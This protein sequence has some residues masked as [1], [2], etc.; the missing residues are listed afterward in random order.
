M[1]AN[2]AK[3][4]GLPRYIPHWLR[5]PWG[6][7]AGVATLYILLYY[8]W[9]YFHWG[10]DDAIIFIGDLSPL[11]VSLFASLAAWRVAADPRLDR[12]LRQAWLFLGLCVFSQFIADAIWSYIEIVL[13]VDAF[14]SAADI[15]YLLFYPMA[16]I[17]LV[18]FREAPLSQGDRLKFA[19]D[20][21]IVMIAAWM[22]IWYFIIVPTAAAN[23]GDLLSQVLAAAYPIGDLVVL[24]G[25]VALLFR[26]PEGATRAAL[27]IFLAGLLVFIAGDL[28]YGYTSLLETYETGGWIDLTW[29]TA[30]LLFAFAALR[31]PY[32]SEATAAEE[33]WERVT[34]R[35]TLTLPFLAIGL[36]YGLLIFVSLQGFT[37]GAQ[38]QGL[39][40][41][42][43][44]LTAAVIGR[45]MVTLRENAR[46]NAELQAFSAE[47]EQRVALRTEELRKS[48]DALFASQKLASVGTLAAGV[49][50]EVSNPLNTILAA[51][52][53]L[54]AKL[55]EPTVDP[56]GLKF[57]IPI[58]NRAA[59]HAARIVQ[60]LRTYSRGSAPELTRQNLAEVVDDALLLMGYQ[61]KKWDNVKLVTELDLDLPEVVCDRNQIAQVM[62][63]LLNNARDAMADGGTVTLR[64]RHTPEGAVIEVADQ[65]MGIAPEAVSKIFDPFFTTKGIG[66]GSG[67][68]LSIVTG[69]LRA[70]NGTIQV[71]S[72]GL[73]QGATFTVTLP[74][75]AEE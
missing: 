10:G 61:L 37:G 9:T 48:Q 17:G 8:A 7:L 1:N 32:L 51:A 57:Y 24:G 55:E 19:L 12:R 29:I 40:I 5:N 70:H 60:A 33:G 49:V 2:Q 22:L 50:H 11:P 34:E 71:H 39:F 56:E 26:R 15:F 68:G 45:Q 75:A 42:A 31:Q 3:A 46:L 54:E 47:L 58:I 72:D 53:S 16:L 41:G 63:N 64:T 66:R 73:G 62:I 65:G 52:D 20:L 30:Y 36:G 6:I 59:W 74:P 14:P 27:L 25:I 4:D 23:E 69:I 67:L 38:V 13:Q 21:S 18:S 44:L 28:L 35:L 43:A